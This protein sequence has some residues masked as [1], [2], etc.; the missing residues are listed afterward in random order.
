MVVFR[1]KTYMHTQQYTKH[2]NT[3]AQHKTKTYTTIHEHIRQQTQIPIHTHNAIDR[4][5][6]QLQAI[7]TSRQNIQ[8]KQIHTH[9]CQHNTH[10]NQQQ[11]L[12]KQNHT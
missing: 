11:Y 7:H 5:H 10:T 3:N 12:Q 9:K 8:N 2:A 6:K 4:Q 1:D